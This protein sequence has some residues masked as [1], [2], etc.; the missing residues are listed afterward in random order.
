MTAAQGEK[1]RDIVRR[2]TEPDDDGDE[3]DGDD[4]PTE[5]DPEAKAAEPPALG[6]V[7][8]ERMGKQVERANK[9]YRSALEKVEG[10][11][12]SAFAECAT[13]NGMGF[14]PPNFVAPPELVAA[15]DK[16]LCHGCN[17]Y[18]VQ[19]TPSLNEQHQLEQCVVCNGN[20][21]KLQAIP[22]PQPQP[23]YMPNV[24]P[25]TTAAQG[26]GDANGLA[27][28]ATTDAWQ[29]PVG[30]PHFGIPPASLGV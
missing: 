4:E 21:W 14:V 13:C 8:V 24:P 26:P 1:Y 16:A 17:G 19:T 27:M 2:E 29:R 28:P 22:E 23:A 3:G 9:N 15:P 11:E 25:I 7:D 10:L 18:G 20:G 5:P 30:H 12:F 6:E